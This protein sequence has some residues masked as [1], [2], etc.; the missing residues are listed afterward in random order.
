[1]EERKKDHIQ[2]AFDSRLPGDTPDRRFDYEPLGSAHPIEY[3]PFE[4]LGKEYRIPIWISS[5]TGGTKL[6]GTVNQ[7]LARAC[8]EFGMGM[9][10]GSCRI[11]LDD[12]THFMDFDM[13][14]IIGNELP[15]YANLGIAQVEKLIADNELDKVWKL[16]EIQRGIIWIFIY[17]NIC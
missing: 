6:A 3:P 9:G 17:K 4:F 16:L 13:R 11:I 15:L 5:M 8:N 2:L 10:L 14:H 1:M 7:N 12:D